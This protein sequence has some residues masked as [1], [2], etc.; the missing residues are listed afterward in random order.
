MAEFLTLISAEEARAILATF[1]PVGKE[2]VALAQALGRVLAEDFRA[3][4]D[5][6]REIR[7]VMDG[8]AVRAKDTF[9]A[10]DAVPAYLKLIGAVAMGSVFS[11]HVGSGEAVAI[12]TGGVLPDGADAVVM[13]E[14]VDRSDSDEVEI[15]R[16]VSVGDNVIRVGEDIARDEVV[17]PAGT[18]L[19]SQDLGVLAAF[20]VCQ[21]Q[22]F[23]RPRVAVLSTGNEVVPY[24]AQPAPGQVR[25]INQVALAAQCQ[26]CGC[27]VTRAGIVADDAFALRMRLTALLETHDVVMLSGGSSVGTRDVALEVVSSLGT[28]G[29]LFHGINVRPGKPTLVARVGQK[30]VIGLPGVPVSAMVIFDVFMRS[31]L[32]RVGGERLGAD[33]IARKR[34]RFTRRHASAPGREDWIRVRLDGDCAVPLLGGSSSIATMV[35]AH[36]YVRVE[37][38]CE[39]IDEGAD[40]EVLLFESL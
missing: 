20:G 9:G 38:G 3:P 18:R 5:L 29:V 39:G 21:L 30:P 32:R 35:Q 10:S 4:E 7:A 26:T 11:G 1:E 6:P 17:V 14:Y 36:G 12:S 31:M 16:G 15:H 27:E 2:T 24:E 34:A 23:C 8:Y 40:V 19:R 25:D 33:W 13:L 22:V 28:P 37:A